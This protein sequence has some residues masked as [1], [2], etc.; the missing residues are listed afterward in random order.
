MTSPYLQ[1]RASGPSEVLESAPHASRGSCG[2]QTRLAERKTRSRFS[3]NYLSRRLRL[4]RRSRDGA[5]A[6]EFAILAI[7]YLM[8]VFAILETFVAFIAE[9]V[10]YAAV[11]KLGREIRTGN[12][13]YNLSRS[14]DQT[15][16]GFRQLVC[17]EI[18][19][20]L[21]CNA[22]E[23]STPTRLW[24]DVRSFSAFSAIPTTISTSSGSLDTSSFAF[25]PGGA[26]TINMV[27]FYYYW[28]VTVDLVRP[29][30]SNIKLPGTTTTSDYL[31]IATTAFQNED[32]P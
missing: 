7:P 19:I 1:N 18:S 3:W 2:P 24:I 15:A 28:P 21:S 31:I 4:F 22:T 14:T 23:V 30:I 13:T 12:I 8:I 9:Q 25:T 32:Y 17:D 11:D 10:V 6:I 26:S 29:Y 16:A 20:L 5:A 27:R